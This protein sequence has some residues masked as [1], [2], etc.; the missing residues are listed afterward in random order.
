MMRPPF[1]E[2][3][4][5]HSKMLSLQASVNISDATKER[6]GAVIKSLYRKNIESFKM[7]FGSLTIEVQHIEHRHFA[8][9]NIEVEGLSQLQTEVGGL[10]G[11]DSH[12]AETAVPSSCK[13][14]SQRFL[15]SIVSGI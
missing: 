4:M 1:G 5:D 8:Y 13:H 15:L 3:A 10:L 11:L 12:T 7:V 9:L 2:V 6:P 14:K